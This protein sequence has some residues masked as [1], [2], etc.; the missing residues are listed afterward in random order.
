MQPRILVGEDIVG[1]D[2][3]PALCSQPLL[4][5]DDGTPTNLE[6]QLLMWSHVSGIVA[7][8]AQSLRYLIRS[9]AYS[10]TFCMSDCLSCITSYHCIITQWAISI[11]IAFLYHCYSRSS[12]S[13]SL[14]PSPSLTPSILT[15]PSCSLS[16]FPLPVSHRSMCEGNPA[17]LQTELF[18]ST[19]WQYLCP[20]QACL[21]TNLQRLW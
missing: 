13:L 4:W 12:L 8:S 5:I 20:L 3:V 15:T 19:Q 7:I 9:L 6:R 18:P 1:A 2:V 11:A 16:F 17:I 10:S 21:L 14:S